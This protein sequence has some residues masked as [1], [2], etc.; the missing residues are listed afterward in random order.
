[1]AAV[2]NAPTTLF[3]I[4]W[5]FSADPARSIPYHD[6][7]ESV[8]SEEAMIDED[9]LSVFN[10]VIEHEVAGYEQRGLLFG[11]VKLH[12]NFPEPFPCRGRRQ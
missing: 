2:A 1:M 10:H 4:N 5:Y 12:A 8:G 11:P 9:E 6:R 7:I 3:D